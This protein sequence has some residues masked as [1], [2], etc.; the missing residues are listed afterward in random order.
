VRK[1]MS[2]KRGTV[3]FKDGDP[4]GLNLVAVLAREELIT[5]GD[6]AG[7]FLAEEAAVGESGTGNDDDEGKGDDSAEAVHVNLFPEVADRVRR[8]AS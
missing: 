6:V 1:T 3:D 8:I 5:V 7:G 4:A 2:E